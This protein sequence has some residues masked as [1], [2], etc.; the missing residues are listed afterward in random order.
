MHLLQ[1]EVGRVLTLKY[2]RAALLQDY[3]GW[4]KSNL[5]K[6]LEIEFDLIDLVKKHHRIVTQEFSVIIQAVYGKNLDQTESFFLNFHKEAKNIH[7]SATAKIVLSLPASPLEGTITFQDIP[8]NPLA[9][10][11]LSRKKIDKNIILLSYETE[12][13]D[14]YFEVRK[15]DIMG[16]H[17]E[18]INLDFDPFPN[19]KNDEIVCR[20]FMGREL[21]LYAKLEAP[22]G[23]I[24]LGI[25]LKLDGH[26]FA[27]DKV[28]CNF[29]AM[30]EDDKAK[31][32]IQGAEWLTYTEPLKIISEIRK[33]LAQKRTPKTL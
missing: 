15:N 27:L 9:E 16:F 21:V 23:V 26:K 25:A 1:E 32:D 7:E 33:E 10:L 22:F 3:N 6:R 5:L 18:M 13:R 28:T 20:A 24:S 30:A 14:R 11:G 31:F 19:A 8:K 17:S 2:S 4:K 29:N 12:E